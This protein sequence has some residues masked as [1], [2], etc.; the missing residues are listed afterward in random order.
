[1]SADA[2]EGQRLQIPEIKADRQAVSYLD[3][4][5]SVSQ[6]VLRAG[7]RTEKI[8]RQLDSI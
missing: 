8:K 1:M 4:A 6:Q 7:G 3:Q 5:S 2:L